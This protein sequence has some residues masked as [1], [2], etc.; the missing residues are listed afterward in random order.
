MK[1]KLILELDENDRIASGKVPALAHNIK[2][3]R[4]I[5][6]TGE[7]ENISRSI[8]NVLSWLFRERKM[9]LLDCEVMEEK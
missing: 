8:L 1:I 9:V 5:T 6:G 3:Y 2:I 4:G 7:A